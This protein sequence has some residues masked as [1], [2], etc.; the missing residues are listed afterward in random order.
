VSDVYRDHVRLAPRL[1]VP[2]PLEPAVRCVLDY[3]RDLRLRRSVE[4][5]QL[6]VLERRCRRRPATNTA[7]RDASDMHV[8]AR[9]GYIHV[10][11]VHPVLMHRP[12]AI[13]AEL[14]EGGRDMW[15]DGGYEKV[16][17]EIRYEEAWQRETRRRR[18]R[19]R[20]RD[21]ALEA[22]DTLSRRGNPDGTDR[23][24]IANAGLVPHEAASATP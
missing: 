9:D 11:T 16:F 18:R 15:A 12:H 13:V 23:T 3:D 6:Y 21:I 1:R 7:M 22:F 5:P 8:Q 20:F 4:N 19:Q 2:K 24:R 17:D 10:S 14:K